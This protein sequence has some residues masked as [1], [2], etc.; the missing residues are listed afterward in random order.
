MNHFFQRF[1][2][3][4][5]LLLF[6][7]HEFVSWPYRHIDA[8]AERVTFLMGMVGLFDRYIASVNMV[9][10]SSP[11]LGIIED[12]SVNVIGFLHAAI[13]DLDWQFHTNQTLSNQVELARIK[14]A[15]TIDVRSAAM[16]E[17]AES[18]VPVGF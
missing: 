6:I 11:T 4:V 8:A 7:G 15:G 2:R 18:I 17:T 3:T 1:V 10:K 5:V 12:Q 13:S 9:A 16:I 14:N